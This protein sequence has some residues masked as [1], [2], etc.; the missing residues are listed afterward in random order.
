MVIS[1]VVPTYN[2]KGLLKNCL[3]ALFNQTYPQD[4]YEILVSDDGSSD[5]TNRLVK[6]I[7]KKHKNLRYFKQNHQGPAAARNLGI[8]KAKGRIIA[9]TDDDCLPQKDW[10]QQIDQVFQE[11]PKTLGIEGKT[12]T[13]SPKT[14]LFTYTVTNQASGQYWT[15]NIAYQRR[16]LNEVGGF[17][18]EFSYAHCEDI[19]LAQRV[20][21]K[22]PIVFA[23]K[24][25]VVHPLRKVGVFSGLKRLSHL[26]DEFRLY[27]KHE[28]HFSQFFPVKNHLAVFFLLTFG[29]QISHRF[30][31]LKDSLGRF[32][33][34]PLVWSKFLFKNLLEIVYVVTVFPRAVWRTRKWQ[35]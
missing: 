20:L 32:F 35:K 34:N 24:M 21:K 11:N 14:S 26:E 19:D 17:D 10:L 8:K 2:R 6:N 23:P 4:E 31:L 5:G 22:G 25:I 3:S 9:L 15:C 30:R 29:N 27:L 7:A 33:Q 18:Q 16:T 13:G 1:V 12:I 28:D